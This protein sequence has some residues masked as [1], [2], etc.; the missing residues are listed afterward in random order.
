VADYLIGTGGW[1]YY[2]IP[3][4]HPLVAY[5]QAFNFVEVNSTFY[6]L[7]TLRE[8]T[9]WRELVPP[10]FHFAVRA[11]RTI[12]HKHKL[13][14]TEEALETLERMKQI[15]VI[16]KV[17][18][19][20]LQ[21]PPSFKLTKASISGINSLLASANLGK[22]R[23]ALELRGTDS[24][25]LPSDLIR[26][27]QDNNVIHCVDLSKNEVPAYQ[28]DVLY[29]RLFGKG[30]HNVYQPTDDEL[31]EIDKKAMATKA[32]KITMSFHFIRMYKDAAR[33]KVYKQTGKFPQITDSTGLASLEEVL[34]E[35]AAFPTTKQQ[36]IQNQG[37]KLFDATN[38]ER[39]HTSA[40]LQ[41][42]PERTYNDIRDVIDTLRLIAG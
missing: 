12:T 24:E 41:K 3:G 7:P 22:T 31:A 28:S 5:S 21:S 13:Q 6:Q 32:E 25:K 39:M 29:S 42:L 23:I 14:P 35:D 18:V 10:D 11:H 4:L 34:R 30:Q 26:I 40:T 19:L 2:Q 17:D 1:A 20:H 8:A 16:L 33:M 36:L 9:R 27:M 38:T 15:C 37:W